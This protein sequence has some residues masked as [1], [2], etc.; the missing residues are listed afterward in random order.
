MAVALA[1]RPPNACS[2]RIPAAKGRAESEPNHAQQWLM[3]PHVATNDPATRAAGRVDCNRDAHA[4]FV[5][6][7][8]C[9]G[10]DHALRNLA[11]CDAEPGKP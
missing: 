9:F 11:M 8:G 3:R 2:H 6:A 4:G 10:F 5:A 1:S 7:H